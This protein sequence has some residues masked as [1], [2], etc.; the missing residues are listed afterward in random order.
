MKV[1]EILALATVAVALPG[2]TSNEGGGLVARIYC[3]GR[4]PPFCITKRAEQAENIGCN[5]K[6]WCTW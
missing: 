6:P 1:F 2:S 3:P 4:T 5:G